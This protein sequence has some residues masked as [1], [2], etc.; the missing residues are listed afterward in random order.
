MQTF[1][2]SIYQNRNGKACPTTLVIANLALALG[3][4]LD[5]L[6]PLDNLKNN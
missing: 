1:Q 6:L 2:L 3:V 5:T 4:T